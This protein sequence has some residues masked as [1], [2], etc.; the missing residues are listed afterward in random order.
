MNAYLI[1]CR[2]AL[3]TMAKN[4]L[5][6]VLLI[7]FIP[8]W[9]TV[10]KTLTTPKTFPFRL[11]ATG[12]ELEVLEGAHDG[13]RLVVFE[14]PSMAAIRLFWE[15]PQ[16]IKIKKLREGAASIDVWAVPAK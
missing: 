9:I 8:M 16:Y 2:Y 7:V 12:T 3:L 11:R 6:A 10:A 5:A 13:R 1:A 14:F 4:R 15:S